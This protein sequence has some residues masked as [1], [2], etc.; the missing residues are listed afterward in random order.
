VR[1]NQ[2]LAADVVLGVRA[3]VR[4]AAG[5]RLIAPE[6]AVDPVDWVVEMRRFDE[7]ATMAAT[8]AR[9]DLD[10]VDAA[11]GSPAGSRAAGPPSWIA[12]P[13][14][15]SSSMGHGDLRAEHVLLENG[16]VTIVDRLE[17]DWRLRRVDVADDV[18]FLVMDLHALGA[19][20]AA[21]ALIA[22]SRAPRASSPPSRCTGRRCGPRSGCSA[23]RSFRPRA[24][25]PRRR[26]AHCG[27]SCSP[28]ASHGQRA[29]GL[30]R[31][32][33]DVR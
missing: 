11:R 32:R 7:G 12:G 22:A 2:A 27:S 9:G 33:R 3:V 13:Q 17:F 18:A 6:D 4:D 30:G 16:T 31:R 25:A 5:C 10:V 19:D 29:D 23:P 26:I 28:S 24:R 1:V 8:I 15:A 14:R 20:W 21:E